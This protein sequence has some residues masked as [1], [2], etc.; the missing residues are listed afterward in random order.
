MSDVF[1]PE[2]FLN[3]T[4]SEENSTEILLVP[5]GE[6]TAVTEPVSA[7]NFKTFDYKS[8][9]RAGQKGYLLKLNW[10][11]ND[12]DGSLKEYLGREPKVQQ[13]LVLDMNKDGALDFGKGRNVGLGRLREAFGQNLTGRPWS[14]AMLGS[15]VAK[16]KV[17]HRLDTASGRT[18]VEIS[19][20]TAG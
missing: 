2:L 13:G 17:K 6:Y 19:E 15:Q 12:E 10:V 11:I 20:V 8:G 7:D 3:Q 1:N 16:V 14:F 5:E 4:F 18:F 9:D